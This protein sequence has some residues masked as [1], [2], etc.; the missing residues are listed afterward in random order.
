MTTF[1]LVRDP[2]AP[3][4]QLPRVCELMT[5]PTQALVGARPNA[6]EAAYTGRYAD[7]LRGWEAQ[8]ARFRRYLAVECAAARLPTATA[9]ALLELAGSEHWATLDRTA[10]KAVG[11]FSIFRGAGTMPAGTIRKGHRFSRAA[12]PD[13]RPAVNAAQYVS[14]APVYV[15]SGQQSVTI[16][17]EAIT[18]GTDPNTI[19]FD[20]A[21]YN[22]TSVDTIFD[23]NFFVQSL[24]A[25]GGSQGIDD[26]WGRLVAMASYAGQFGPNEAALIAGA[27]EV[28]RIRRAFPLLDSANAVH[29][30]FVADV[31]WGCSDRLRS[32]VQQAIRDKWLGWGAKVSVLPIHNTL[33]N[34]TAS[35]TLV[36]PQYLDDTSDI[37]DNVRGALKN[38]FDEKPDFYT[39]K[40]RALRGLISQCDSRILKCTSVSVLDSSGVTIPEPSALSESAQ[41][42]THF[43]LNDDALNLTFGIPS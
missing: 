3:D 8:A 1:S 38:Y 21:T 12:D 42:A 43:Y 14:T 25:A 24:I 31:S 34:V 28:P 29:K 5:P 16:P 27:F 37:A 7:I 33:V 13:A 10:Q 2:D 9:Q 26:P 4:P 32:L 6:I 35:I 19:L 11:E 23:S 41:A 39:F 36:G 18:T 30:L 15:A 20:F 40:L 22:G 17:I